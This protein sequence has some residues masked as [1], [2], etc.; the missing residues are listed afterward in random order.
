MIGGGL[1]DLGHLIV[2]LADIAGVDAHSAATG[3]DG[4]E[5]VLRL[6]VDVRDDRNAG[7]RGDDRQRARVLVGGAGHA[8]DVATGGR[9]FGDLLESGAD[10]VGLRRR[11]RLNRD[12][13]VT[14]DVQVANLDPAGGP[15]RGEDGAFL[16]DG[17]DAKS[18]G[19]SHALQYGTRTGA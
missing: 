9:Q 17:G 15:A 5:D 4:R 10:V 2:E 7:L 16:T 13:G 1:A 18:N 8:H 12:G 14:A 6:E 11:H 19:V 3:L